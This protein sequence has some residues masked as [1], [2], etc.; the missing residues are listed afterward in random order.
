MAFKQKFL[1]VQFQLAEGGFDSTQFNVITLGTDAGGAGGV[2]ATASISK[3]GT[4]SLNKLDLI[5]RGMTLSQINQL[6]TLGKPLPSY[7]N[8]IVTVT[9]YEQDG[10][11]TVA[12]SGTIQEAWFD[13]DGMPNATFNVSAF[14][15][16]MD[17]VTPAPPVS[18]SGATDVGQVMSYLATLMS[19]NFVN[20]GVTGVIAANPYFAG[21]LLTQAQTCARNYHFNMDIDDSTKTLTI[22]PKGSVKS[23]DPIDVSA[24]TGMIGY[25]AHTDQ[26]IA[27]RTLYNPNLAFGRAVKVTSQLKPA[28]GQN[29]AIFSLVHE[30][31]AGYPEAS[32]W[33]STFKSNY[34]GGPT[35]ATAP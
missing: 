21:S 1:Q 34:F 32:K 19:L 7:R 20:D 31:E 6:S 18:Y 27:V 22:W 30:L 28:T 11:K 23:G 5:V 29:W 2:G 10:P 16:L 35:I 13:G 24:E 12:F 26:G 3:N 17:K 33:Q 8:N 9:A 14:G 25:P 4:P 15:Q